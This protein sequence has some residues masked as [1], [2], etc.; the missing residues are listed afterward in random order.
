MV[1]P[2]RFRA[3]VDLH[4][5]RLDLKDTAYKWLAVP[6]ILCIQGPPGVGKSSQLAQCLRDIRSLTRR[7]NAA[8]LCGNF[9]G[10]P[11][12]KLQDAFSEL[13]NEARD[14]QRRPTIVIDDFDL[15]V[16]TLANRSYTVNTQLV[17]GWLMAVADDTYGT[18]AR[19]SPAIVVT[20]N[21]FS[22]VHGPLLRT[23]RARVFNYD[24]TT[25]EKDEILQPI[26][27]HHLSSVPN[28]LVSEFQ[29][30][31]VSDFVEALARL[32]DGSMLESTS[33]KSRG[34]SGKVSPLDP[35]L[36]A[37]E[38]RSLWEENLSVRN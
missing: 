3:A 10:D 17:V 6:R 11:V 23:G 25:E 21:D 38:L 5:Q 14:T 1:I 22:A 35:T 18:L 20:G 16:G 7:L 33:C 30:L 28:G 27:A 29:D 12:E 13:A 31:S 26:F 15:S 36:Y 24:P 19:H 4:F 34:R 2:S 9:E 32:R 8:D 37:R